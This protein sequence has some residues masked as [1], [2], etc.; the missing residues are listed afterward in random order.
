MHKKSF[1]ELVKEAAWVVYG[2][3]LPPLYID[4]V[5]SGKLRLREAVRD[6]VTH[7]SEY[8]SNGIVH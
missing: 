7:D 4:L 3:A 2:V 1:P 6:F 8:K 5:V